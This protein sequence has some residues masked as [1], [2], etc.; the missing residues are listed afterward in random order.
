ML[1]TMSANTAIGYAENASL[2]RHHVIG[3]R[4]TCRKEELDRAP[5]NEA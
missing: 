1:A 3:L 5:A 4:V 2:A